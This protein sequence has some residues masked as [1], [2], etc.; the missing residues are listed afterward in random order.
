MM[1]AMASGQPSQKY[2]ADVKEK[3]EK[4]TMEKILQ[5]ESFKNTAPKFKSDV[6]TDLKRF[7]TAVQK[8]TLE[9]GELSQHQVGYFSPQFHIFKFGV[10]VR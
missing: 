4:L 5:N 3:K 9:K 8:Q 1:A 10:L 6:K 7:R 2:K